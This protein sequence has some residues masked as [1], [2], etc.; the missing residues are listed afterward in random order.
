MKPSNRVPRRNRAT[1]APAQSREKQSNVTARSFA[2]DPHLPHGAGSASSGVLLPPEHPLKNGWCEFYCVCDVADIG[3]TTDGEHWLREDQIGEDGIEWRHL[4]PDEARNWILE[5]TYAGHLITPDTA[6]HA[7]CAFAPDPEATFR[8]TLP[9]SHILSHGWESVTGV[10]VLG[11]DLV[12][13]RD[14][15]YWL[16]TLTD[17]GTTT[18]AA[19]MNRLQSRAWLVDFFVPENLRFAVSEDWQGIDSSWIE[20]EFRKNKALLHLLAEVAGRYE[21]EN[22]PKGST[23]AAGYCEMVSDAHAALDQFLDQMLAHAA[24]VYHLRDELATI[25]GLRSSNQAEE[26]R[27]A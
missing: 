12:Q 2:P 13:A 5:Q 11:E 23:L 1:P 24:S 3:Q 19:A 18:K 21:E 6:E 17:D 25:Q 10:P 4:T 16:L 27:A 8:R 14:H 15:T 26:R 7:A 22:D 20:T 9:S